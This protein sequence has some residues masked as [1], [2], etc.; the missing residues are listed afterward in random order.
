MSTRSSPVSGAARGSRPFSAAH[1][2][3]LP[4]LALLT[5]LAW[6]V[7][8][9]ATGYVVL[10]STA[11]AV[12]FAGLAWAWPGTWLRLLLGGY[13]ILSVLILLWRH[14]ANFGRLI[15]GKEHRSSRRWKWRK[16]FRA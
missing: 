6:A 14:R 16:D 2:P 3:W 4:P 10:A 12:V 13:G 1:L 11:S 9:Y 7:I 8:F 5:L 15:A